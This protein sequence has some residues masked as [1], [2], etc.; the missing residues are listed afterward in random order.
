MELQGAPLTVG[1]GDIVHLVF[2][3][4]ISGIAGQFVSQLPIS[5]IAGQFVSQLPISTE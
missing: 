4:P 3:L 2:Q 1:A 5:G